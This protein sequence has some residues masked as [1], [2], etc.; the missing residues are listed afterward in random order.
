[1]DRDIAIGQ[2]FA[3]NSV[4]VY[5]RPGWECSKGQIMDKAWAFKE[6]LDHELST[7]VAAP[8]AG[9]DHWMYVQQLDGNTRDRANWPR[10][11]EWLHDHLV[12]FH[13]TVAA[14]EDSAA[15]D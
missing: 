5:A 4:G 15:A 7:T 3:M 9:D 2:W 10:M 11:I 12:K 8:Y 13:R 1:M 14:A 6:P